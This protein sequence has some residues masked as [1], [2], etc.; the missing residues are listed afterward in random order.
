MQK[1]RLLSIH[2]P[3]KRALNYMGGNF[4]KESVSFIQQLETYINAMILIVINDYDK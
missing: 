4:V 2:W 1:E 3:W